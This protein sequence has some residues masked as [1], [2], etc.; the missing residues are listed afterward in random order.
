MKK[1]ATIVAVLAL[2]VVVVWVLL[3]RFR[4]GS[5]STTAYTTTVQLSGTTN[6]SFSGCYVRDG[7]RITFS[8]VLPWS[9]SESNLFRFEARKAKLED[10]LVVDAHGGGS[11]LTGTAGPGSRGLRVEME[12]GW[13]FELIK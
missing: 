7:K 6:A 13:S 1:L 11:M 4:S 2:M 5:G 8:G 3:P 12:N 10:T 9:L